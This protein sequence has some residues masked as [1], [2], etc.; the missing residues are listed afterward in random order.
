LFYAADLAAFLTR[1]RQAQI[2]IE[3][4]AHDP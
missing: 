3:P 1:L 4:T 2:K